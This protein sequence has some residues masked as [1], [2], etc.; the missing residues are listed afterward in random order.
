MMPYLILVRDTS[1]FLL[2]ASYFMH[3]SLCLVFQLSRQLKLVSYGL[4]CIVSYA[5]NCDALAV[6]DMASKCTSVLHRRMN[7]AW[8]RRADKHVVSM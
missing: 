6:A 4:I 5:P 1:L 2:A 3:D 7:Y 8:A